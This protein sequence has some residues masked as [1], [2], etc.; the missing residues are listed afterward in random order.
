[1]NRRAKDLILLAAIG[2]LIVALNSRLFIQ[3]EERREDELNGDRSTYTSRPFGTKAFFT[4]L[5]RVG[6]PVC[7]WEEPL[8]NL[9]ER[10]HGLSA[11]DRPPTVQGQVSEQHDRRVSALFMIEPTSPLTQ[12][13]SSQLSAWVRR[14]GRLILVGRSIRWPFVEDSIQV[15]AHPSRWNIPRVLLPSLLTLGVRH[16]Q[17]TPHA[18]H[19]EVAS[20]PAVAHI[21][22]P[23]GSLLVDLRYGQ[24]QVILLGEPFVLAN[25]GLTSADNV[26]LAL[27]L[28]S[29]LKGGVVAFDERLHAHPGAPMVPAGSAYMIVALWNYVAR[30]SARPAFIQI[31]V[32]VL[33]A[34]Y[35]SSRRFGQVRSRPPAERARSY[36]YVT[37]LAAMW[38][39][40]SARTLALENIYRGF[41][42]ALSKSAG[43]RGDPAQPENIEMICQ[44]TGIPVSRLRSLIDRCERALESDQ[45]KESELI[46]LTTEI[47]AIEQTIR[48]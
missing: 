17:L 18:A 15:S 27:N 25:N 48:V 19:I 28:V 46:H 32:I 42:M 45:L 8:V 2:A 11:T 37:A 20:G 39:G 35:S 38:E 21:G 31:G 30:S 3:Q 34:L 9:I 40:M 44:R 14:G 22:D 5:E 1:M 6:L 13:E 41:T 43:V 4:L 24:G 7:R 36:E 47:R 23:S 29:N 10:G 33:L 26:V 16:V 12:E